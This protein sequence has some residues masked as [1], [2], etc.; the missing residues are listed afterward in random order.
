MGSYGN[1]GKRFTEINRVAMTTVLTLFSDHFESVIAGEWTTASGHVVADGRVTL[2]AAGSGGTAALETTLGSTLDILSTV[3]EMLV[4]IPKDWES[5][6]ILRFG[7]KSQTDATDLIFFEVNTNGNLA[8]IVEVTGQKLF[9]ET[10]GNID[11]LKGSESSYAI[12]VGEDNIDFLANGKSVA[13]VDLQKL[14]ISP[15]TNLYEVF[16]DIVNNGTASQEIVIGYV[17]YSVAANSATPA[18]ALGAVSILGSVSTKPVVVPNGV[19]TKIT[20]TGAAS[21]TIL[22]AN[23]AR[24]AGLVFN[25]S[26]IDLL[27]SMGAVANS[28]TGIY[29]VVL[30]DDDYFETPE[31][32][33]GIITGEGTGD[34][35]ATELT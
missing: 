21:Q 27:L 31:G 33:T 29:S 34:I 2:T 5:G 19:T 24:R 10:V 12:Q 4:N 20:M 22:A 35:R 1:F 25:D 28:A 9:R 18:G 16:F 26:G 23:A 30:K 6:A 3:V 17:E 14:E 32:Y 7:L 8:F 11:Y 13:S 15:L